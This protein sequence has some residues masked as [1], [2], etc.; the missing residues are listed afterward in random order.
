MKTR[1]LSLCIALLMVLGL[2]LSACGGNDA[3]PAADTPAGNQEPAP[4]QNNQPAVQPEGGETVELT[5]GSWRTDDVAQMNNLLA[6]YKAVAPNVTITFQP[7]NPPDYNATL[8]LQLEGGTGPDLMYA[9]SYATGAELFSAGYFYDCSDI[10][11]LQE[12]FSSD[13]RGPWTSDGKSFAVPFAAVSHAVYYNKDIFAANNLSIP[14]T[15]ED[16]I[17]V[18]ETLKAAGITPLANGVADEWDILECFFLGMVPN[19]VGGAA[20]R[21]KYEKGEK[22]MNSAE[23]VNAYTDFGSV[24]QYLPQ[25]FEAITYNDSQVM[26]NTGTAAM[27]MDGSWTAGVYDGAPFEW[28]LFA[29]PARAASD[30]AVCFHM[31]MAITMNANSAHP[32][33]AKAFLAWLCTQEGATIASQ[34][35]PLGYFPVIDFPITLEDA[36]VNEFLQLN[37]GKTTDV[38]FVWPELMDLYAPMNQAIISLLKGDLTPQAAADAV[39]AEYQKLGR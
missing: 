10:P 22:P 37:E 34:N 28:G 9:R 7:T 15:W 35:L 18:C 39:E 2:G 19:Y 5:M 36:H 21:E 24:A 29:I 38:R 3:P 17:K 26:F 30:T 27:F 25:G 14:T 32:E 8:R 6:A 12:N 13:A 20:E 23:F 1:T 16:F 4:Q 31:D 33:E 11:G